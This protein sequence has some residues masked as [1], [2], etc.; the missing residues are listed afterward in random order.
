ALG[1]AL[2][3]LV[4]G[5]FKYAGFILTN[6]Q[7]LTG[8]PESIPEISLPIGISFYT[9]QL[10]T[11]IIDVYRGD[12][13]AQKRYDKLLLY[14]S[15]FHQCIAGPIVRYSDISNE[16]TDRKP[17]FDDF[18]KGV[19]RFSTGLA[20][21]VLLANN[22]GSLAD[23]LLTGDTTALADSISL[24]SSR[25]ALS[26]W[27]GMIFYMLQLYLDFSAYSDMA[28]GMGLMTGF[29]YRENFDYPYTSHSVTEFWRR[30]HISLSSFFRDYVYIPLGGNRKGKARRFFNLFIVWTLTGL[31]HGA[32]W[33]YVLWGLYF[34]VFL[35]LEKTFLSERLKKAPRALSCIYT[36]VI[37][38]FSWVLFKFED[39][40]LLKTALK[41]MFGLNGNPLATHES[42]V[43]TASN[44]PF[45]IL[46]AVSTTPIVKY[47]QKII[48]RLSVRYSAVN[49]VYCIFRAVIPAALVILSAVCL[50]G[51]SYN[52][53][54]YFRF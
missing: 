8:F 28:I 48:D 52:P 38:Y 26:V 34:F 11:Y 13:P 1:C 49:T 46:A 27:V 6:I 35:V 37:V 14:A 32:S 20:K 51:D 43:Y 19:M 18:N 7:S 25:S 30:W 21:K 17:N 4:L 23:A 54:L 3:I 36:L 33:N 22:C 45:L 5:I 9:F 42:F 44:L 29:H 16:I 31:W 15:L 39:M 24:L 41:G 47:L 10:M 2:A 40:T 50:V 12:A 53:F